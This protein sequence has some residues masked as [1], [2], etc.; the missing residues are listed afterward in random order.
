MQDEDRLYREL[1][2]EYVDANRNVQ[3]LT[4]LAFTD[5][6]EFHM[7]GPIRFCDHATCQLV[8]RLLSA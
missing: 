5:H 2:A 7:N 6:H 4:E 3:T 8:A 1:L